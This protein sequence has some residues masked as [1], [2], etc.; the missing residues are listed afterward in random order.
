MNKNFY[1]KVL[2]RCELLEIIILLHPILPYISTIFKAINS[3]PY[4]FPEF[5]LLSRV[6][7]TMDRTPM[8]FQGPGPTIIMHINGTRSLIWWCF[9][10]LTEGPHHILPAF[11]SVVT[12]EAPSNASSALLGAG[13]GRTWSDVRFGKCNMYN[14]YI[15]LSFLSDVRILS[16]NSAIPSHTSLPQGRPSRVKVLSFG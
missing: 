5:S 15:Y 11:L 2:R 10:E 4:H 7:H 12:G 8:T 9:S 3:R 6:R 14:Q 16:A 13:R 1:M